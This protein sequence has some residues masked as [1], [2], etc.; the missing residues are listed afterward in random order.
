LGKQSPRLSDFQ[1][2][3]IHYY[4]RLQ[5]KRT[6][7]HNKPAPIPLST[8]QGHVLAVLRKVL[9]YSPA[10]T[11]LT[12][13]PHTSSKTDPSRTQ[14]KAGPKNWE[15]CSV[16]LAKNIALHWRQKHP[17]CKAGPSSCPARQ[18]IVDFGP[19]PP[20]SFSSLIRSQSARSKLYIHNLMSLRSRGL[21]SPA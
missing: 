18:P 15:V 6:S 16:Q 12:S 21:Q 5:I 14:H 1:V 8:G 9:W 7:C 4:P 17:R 10:Y 3:P 19:P 2:V 13:V 11:Y 20:Y